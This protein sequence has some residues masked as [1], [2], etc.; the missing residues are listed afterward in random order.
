MF[1]TAHIYENAN[2]RFKQSVG[3]NKVTRKWS[4]LCELSFSPE[5]KLSL[6]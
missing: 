5:S 4:Y 1:F 3:S 6:G 2:L